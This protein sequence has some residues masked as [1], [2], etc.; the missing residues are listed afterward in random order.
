VYC[1]TVQRSTVLGEKRKHGGFNFHHFIFYLYYAFG[2]FLKSLKI[3]KTSKTTDTP[4][5]RHITP[6]QKHQG[7]PI[8]VAHCS[9]ATLSGSILLLSCLHKRTAAM[10]LSYQM[11]IAIVLLAAL[12]P[13][14]AWNTPN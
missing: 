11:N 6:T 12:R 14:I 8:P 3:C 4:P 5:T 9:H 7:T 10:R 13:S 2:I 1:S